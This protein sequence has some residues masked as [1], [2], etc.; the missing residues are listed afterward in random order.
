[1]EIETNPVL[2]LDNFTALRSKSYSFSYNDTQ[3]AFGIQKAKQKGIQKATKCE[4]YKNSLFMAE[5]TNATKYS[6]RSNLHR[7]TVQYQNNLALNLFDDKRMYLN[8]IQSS[9]WDKH[10]KMRLSLYSLYKVY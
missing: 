4:D 6:I 8:P 7:F 3:S 2:V 9:L 5:T 10:S 1:M